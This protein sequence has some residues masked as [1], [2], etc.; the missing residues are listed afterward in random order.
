MMQSD[1]PAT[2]RVKQQAASSTAPQQAL[3]V[4]NIRFATRHEPRRKRKIEAKW[5]TS[6]K[7]GSGTCPQRTS[8][9]RT[10]AKIESW[11]GDEAK[12]ASVW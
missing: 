11:V 6:S 7:A 3:R 9:A 8:G 10:W 12:T 2:G 5:Q 1:V 4:E